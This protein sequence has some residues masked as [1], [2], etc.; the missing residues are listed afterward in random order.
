MVLSIVSVYNKFF[1]QFQNFLEVKKSGKDFEAKTEADKSSVCFDDFVFCK[2]F[3]YEYGLR[4][5]QGM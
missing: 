1:A 2:D 5:R 4:I 3:A